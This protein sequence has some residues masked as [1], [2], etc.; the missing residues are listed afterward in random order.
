M[1]EWIIEPIV[2][3]E[4]TYFVKIGN[5]GNRIM[6][7]TNNRDDADRIIDACL[8]I[9]ETASAEEY[10]GNQEA[11]ICIINKEKLGLRTED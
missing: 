10:I 9:G 3:P 11:L 2:K 1:D 7:L 6:A 5:N 8:K 4:K